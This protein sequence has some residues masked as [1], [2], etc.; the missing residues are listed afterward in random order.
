MILKLIICITL[1]LAVNASFASNDPSDSIEQ[2]YKSEDVQKFIINKLNEGK[3][4]GYLYFEKKFKKYCPACKCIISI[5]E[6]NE[7]TDKNNGRIIEN[8]MNYIK[9]LFSSFQ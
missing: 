9:K 2:Y 6:C 8:L 3:K 4:S 7:L 1:L 5:F